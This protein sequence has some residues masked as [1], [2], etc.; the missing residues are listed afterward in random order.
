[1]ALAEVPTGGGAGGDAER[2]LQA[3]G[4]IC[5][6]VALG[7]DEQ[8][9][10]QHVT[11]AV[12]RLLGP[13]YARLWMLEEETGDLV[14]V[15]TAGPLTGP[16]EIGQRRPASLGTLN[17]AVLATG[18]IYQTSDVG[19]DPRWFSGAASRRAGL[20]TYLGVPLM[21]GERRY[22]IMA[23]LFRERRIFGS[24]DLE[25]VESVA[26]QA[27]LATQSA[28]LYADARR[29]ARQLATIL[30]VNKRL[31]LGPR[32]DE[33][34]SRVTEEAALLLG[35]EGAT[36]RLLQGDEL[37]RMATFGL[38]ER[39]VVR[40]RLRVGESLIG[41]VAG[42]GC[43]I[44][45]TDPGGDPRHDPDHRTEAGAHGL[46][47]WLGVPLRGRERVVGALAVYTRGD[48]R[49]NEAGATLI[50]AFADQAALAVENAHVLATAERRAAEAMAVAQVGRAITSSLDQQA[51]LELIVDQACRLLRTRRSA[52]A[53]VEP[54]ASDVLFRY[55][56]WRG[57]S[58]RFREHMRPRH[59]RDG[60]TPTAIEERRPVWS[61]DILHDPGFDL[62]PA[63]RAAIELEGYRAVLSVPL[64]IGTRVL[65]ALVVARD[66]I[67][68][69]SADD[70]DLLRLF[71]DQAAIAI[72]NARLFEQAA[73]VE[74]LHELG[75]LK[76]EFLNTVSH[77]LRTPLSLVYG[78]AELLRHRAPSLSPEQVAEMAGELHA[79]ART[80]A[81]LVDDLLDFSQI[82]Q[83]QLELRRRDVAIE[84]VLRLLV[85]TFRH[86]PGGERIETD[87]RDTEAWVDPERLTQVV[88]NLLTNALRYAPE[89]PIVLR[90]A[91]RN[92]RLRVE[93]VDRGQGIPPIEQPRIWERFYRS[94]A[95]VNSPQRGNGLGLAVVKQLVEFHGGRVGLRSTPGEGTTFWLTMPA[96]R[97]GA[98][99]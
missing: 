89:G 51:V 23:L 5:R 52:V 6:L 62:T 67:G 71:A 22:G 28:R 78:Y 25:L 30:D 86:Q 47:A 33:I 61:A 16:D 72:E 32:L 29:R 34:L 10:L 12:T 27:A 60:T 38:G 54:E 55:V 88:G 93:V 3:L 7:G 92:G 43:A 74:A 48:R 40:E 58:D 44:I 50:E 45:S 1:M 17:Q 39:V 57:M 73:T 26:A 49:F 75:R 79:G 11:D 69:F 42:E 90:A 20:H 94:A 53:V 91:R 2:R 68:P 63:T 36:L 13:P 82:E 66:E 64:L 99:Q 37:V 83:G 97:V 9:I 70:V 81:R 21:A 96:G 59:W 14:L 87:I 56:A 18:Q 76:T 98:G 80:M 41:R 46:S 24:D 31:V 85:E 15:A 84:A 35:A 77:E 19:A 95:A 65:G 8:A 4:E